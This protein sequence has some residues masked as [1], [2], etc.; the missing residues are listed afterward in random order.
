V[1]Q[2]SRVLAAIDFS[3]PARDAFDY[4]LALSRRHGAEL[5]AVQAVPTTEPFARHGRARLALAEKL[6]HSA[7]Q[8]GVGFSI[9]VQ[10]GDPAEIVLLHARSLRPDVIVVGTHQRRGRARLRAGSVAARVAARAMVPVFVVPAHRHAS[11]SAPFRHVA[12]AVDFSAGATRAIEHALALANEPADRITLIHVLQDSSGVPRHLY[13]YG[14]DEHED[15]LIRDA[16]RRLHQAVPA[17]RTSAAA[18]DTQ[19]VRGEAATAITQVVESIGAD[20]LIVGA[21]T[22]GVVT[23]ALFGTTAARVLRATPV[24]MLVVPDR[25]RASADADDT[26]LPLAA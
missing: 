8:A 16:R 17:K 19:V 18:I 15:P 14:L 26:A 20:L 12:V 2:I 3:K 21:T 6:W 23:R 24:P 13:G 22:R 10:S 4:A 5:V 25:G 9:R 7:E 11:A 1:K